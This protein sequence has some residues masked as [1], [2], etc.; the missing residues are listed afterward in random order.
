MKYIVN[1]PY[2]AWQEIQVEADNA[3]EAIEKAK[4]A[5]KEEGSLDHYVHEWGVVP[6]EEF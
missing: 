5:D 3:Q 1:V 4:L 2:T 6:V